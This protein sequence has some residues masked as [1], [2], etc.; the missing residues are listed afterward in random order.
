MMFLRPAAANNDLFKQHRMTTTALAALV[1]SP[2]A[3]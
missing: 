3:A 2:S 1:D